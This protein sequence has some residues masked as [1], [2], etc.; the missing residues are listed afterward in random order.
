MRTQV[1]Q[2]DNDNV[3]VDDN[4]HVGVDED[5]NDDDDDGGG[6]DQDVDEDVDNYIMAE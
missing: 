1:A 2:I 3:V 5:I 4:F 6:Y